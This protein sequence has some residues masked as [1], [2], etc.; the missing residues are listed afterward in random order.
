MTSLGFFSPLLNLLRLKTDELSGPGVFSRLW[1]P[2]EDQ[3]TTFDPAASKIHF[4]SPLPVL[5]LERWTV[6][7][8]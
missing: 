3:N 7:I 6:E 2:A 1:Q 5:I 4:D 8:R